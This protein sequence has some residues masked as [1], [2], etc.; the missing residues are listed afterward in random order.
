LLCFIKPI[1][2]N[3]YG[4]GVSSRVTIEFATEQLL[5]PRRKKLVR[6]SEVSGQTREPVLCHTHAY[7]ITG[8]QVDE[9]LLQS[10]RNNIPTQ[11]AKNELGVALHML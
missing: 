3:R 5:S 2:G 8:L 4:P 6:S 1:L 10:Y 9:N 11:N 7:Y